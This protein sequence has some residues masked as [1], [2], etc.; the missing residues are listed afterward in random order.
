MTRFPWRTR[1]GL[2]VIINAV[3]GVFLSLGFVASDV[4]PWTAGAVAFVAL[5]ADLGVVVNGE[6]K[7]TPVA[8]PVGMDGQG[9]VPWS[10]SDTVVADDAGDDHLG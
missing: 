10:A 4:E 1:S 8:D 9:L 6:S 7:T 5:L 3:A 2:L